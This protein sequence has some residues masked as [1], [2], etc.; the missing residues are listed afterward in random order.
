MRTVLITGASRGLGR[1]LAYTFLEKGYFVA[2]NYLHS[3]EEAQIIAENGGKKVITVKADVGDP[4]QVREMI[5]RIDIS[6]GRLDVVI[7]NAGIAR[8]NLLI[9]QTEKEW[10]AIINT[11]LTGCFHVMR[12][13]VPLLISSGG[14]HILNISSYS[15][16][17]GRAGQVAYSASKAALFGLSL[18]AARELAE[19]NIRVNAV[20]PGYMMTEMGSKAFMASE[21]AKDESILHSL[22]NPSKVSQSIF[23]LAEMSYITGQV[24]NLDSRVV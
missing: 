20:L 17:K 4:D 12:A 15:G 3:E 23:S 7:N 21:K 11:N 10:D 8:D 5:S 9:K 1:E 16:M 19:F 22:S 14:G 6:F 2:V 24:L 18:A 13:S